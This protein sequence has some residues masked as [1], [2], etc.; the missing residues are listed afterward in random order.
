M[1]NLGDLAIQEGDF[2]AAAAYLEEALD[3]FQAIGARVGVTTTLLGL[4]S[5]AARLG[6]EQ[7]ARQYYRDG[8]AEAVALEAVPLILYALVGEAGLRCNSD[9]KGAA[10]LLGL[11]LNHPATTTETHCEAAPT[12]DALRNALDPATL[13]MMLARGKALDL[14]TVTRS[15]L[16]KGSG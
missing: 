7:A 3:I 16:G 14:A 6:D 2:P 4:G 15:V 12:L 1:N 9:P 5:L 10:E 8:L 11:A 13:E